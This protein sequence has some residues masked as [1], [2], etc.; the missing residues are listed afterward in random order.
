MIET[1]LEP[2]EVSVGHLISEGEFL[3]KRPHINIAMCGSFMEVSL[4]D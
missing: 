2:P 1:Y 3:V 4:I